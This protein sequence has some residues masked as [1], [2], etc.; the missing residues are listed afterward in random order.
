MQRMDKVDRG[1]LFFL[2]RNT[3]TRGHSLKL[4]VGRVRTD[5][6]KHLFTQHGVSLWNP[7]PQDVMMSSGLDALKR[8]LDRFLEEKSISGYKPW[9]GLIDWFI[10]WLDLYPTHIDQGRSIRRQVSSCLVCSQRHLVGPLGDIGSWTRWALG[11]IQQGSSY[12]L[13]QQ[14]EHFLRRQW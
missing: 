10:D 8:G 7:L 1:K 6:R 11:L 4:S 2:S 14:N 3:R 13:K 9:W 5:K 12:V